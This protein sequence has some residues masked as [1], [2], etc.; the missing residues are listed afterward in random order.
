VA[1]LKKLS[2]FGQKSFLVKKT[3]LKY[4][5]RSIKQKKRIAETP[6][7]IIAAYCESELKEVQI[8][9]EKYRHG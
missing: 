2:T 8:S 7:K 1:T 6:V 3:K 4:I 5:L 9:I